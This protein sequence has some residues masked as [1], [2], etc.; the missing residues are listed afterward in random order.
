M[1]RSTGRT[2][3][4]SLGLLLA[5]LAWSRMVHAQASSHAGL[6]MGWTDGTQGAFTHAVP[7]AVPAFHGIEPRLSLDYNSSGGN[8]NAGAEWALGGFGVIE[9]QSPGKG[10][11]RY[12]A[13]D[14]YM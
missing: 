10:A 3:K 12:D 8:T 14:I 4:V 9:R 13:T 6:D 7:I 11:P 1:N 5:G 2:W